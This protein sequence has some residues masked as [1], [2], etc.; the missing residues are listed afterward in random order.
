MP[1][2]GRADR[3]LRWYRV[4]PALAL[5]L[6]LA[7]CAALSAAPATMTRRLFYPVDHVG[8]I[9]GASARHGVDPD[10]VCAVIKCESGWDEGAVSAAGALG[11]MQ[12]MP[13][14]AASLVELGAVDGAA[15]DPSDLLDP[16]V[17]IEFGCA[18][19]EFLEDRLSSDDEVIAAYNAGI[20]SVKGWIAD[21]STIPEGIEYAETRAYLARV[22]AAWEGYRRSYPEGITDA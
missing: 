12:V 7:A 13:E 19:L 1:R 14:T 10:L 3:L 20:G 16:E 4:V 18:Y 21:G 22:R 11:L 9:L 8:T 5:A 2:R 15:Y 17:N 6:A